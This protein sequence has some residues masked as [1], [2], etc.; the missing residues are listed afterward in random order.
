MENK[1]NLLYSKTYD[2]IISLIFASL[3][4]TWDEYIFT[5]NLKKICLCDLRK[6]LSSP[7]SER[8]VYVKTNEFSRICIA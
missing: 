3:K 7:I 5:K 1:N 4:K 2:I 6:S 8:Q